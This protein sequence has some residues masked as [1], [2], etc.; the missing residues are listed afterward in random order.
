MALTSARDIPIDRASVTPEL[1]SVVELQAM[2]DEMQMKAK[3]QADA[4]R[5][6]MRLRSQFLLDLL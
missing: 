6:G 1:V 4:M 5:A 3:Q 2:T